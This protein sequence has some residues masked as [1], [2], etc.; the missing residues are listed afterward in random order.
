MPHFY[1]DEPDHIIKIEPNDKHYEV[2]KHL[3]K[4]KEEVLSHGDMGKK[5]FNRYCERVERYLNFHS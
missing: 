1:N 5:I 2:R 4:V 3:S